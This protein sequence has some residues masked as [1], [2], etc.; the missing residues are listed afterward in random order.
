MIVPVKPDPDLRKMMMVVLSPDGGV[1]GF[2]SAPD[3]EE[4]AAVSQRFRFKENSKPVSH[5][6]I[7]SLKTQTC[8]FQSES[9]TD[10]TCRTPVSVISRRPVLLGPSAQR[11]FLK[12]ELWAVSPFLD[13]NCAL[14][15]HR[16]RSSGLLSAQNPPRSEPLCQTESGPGTEPS[17]L[18]LTHKT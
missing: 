14:K 18:V 10:R 5:F 11:E 9:L 6:S 13:P 3:G 1:H 8:H 7:S 16:T 2:I 17:G 4:T 15:P 12:P